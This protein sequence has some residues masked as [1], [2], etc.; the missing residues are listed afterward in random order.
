MSKKSHFLAIM[1]M[2]DK[3][4]KAVTEWAEPTTVKER[5]FIKNFSTV[6]APLTSL[7]KWIPKDLKVPSAR[8]TLAQLNKR[9]TSAPVLKLPDPTNPFVVEVDASELGLGGVL[10]QYYRALRRLY[11]CAFFSRKLTVTE[12]NN[13]KAALEEWRHWLEGA[14]HPFTLF[15]N[16]Q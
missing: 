7:L 2:D 10:S 3:R 16:H 13:D 11:Q 5:R 15:T 8:A 6:A 14:R 4:V 9:F 12:R 1:V